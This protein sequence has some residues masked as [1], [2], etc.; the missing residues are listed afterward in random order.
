MA[1]AKLMDVFD[2]ADELLEKFTRLFF[3]KSL[4]LDNNVKQLTTIHEFHHQI[5]IFLSFY[6][7][8]NLYNIWMVQLFKDLDFSRYTLYVFL[9]LDTWLLKYFYGDL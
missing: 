8:I 7:F 6:D 2:T 5:E 4:I 1:D 3:V 9:V